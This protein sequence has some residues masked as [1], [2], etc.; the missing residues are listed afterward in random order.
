[1]HDDAKF[2][3]DLADFAA[4]VSASARSLG[5][6]PVLGADEPILYVDLCTG[7]FDRRKIHKAIHV[8]IDP[9]QKCKFLG[10]NISGPTV[11]ITLER[12]WQFLAF[13]AFLARLLQKPVM[14]AN[15]L[16]RGNWVNGWEDALKR[17]DHAMKS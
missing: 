15:P 6:Y 12:Q 8:N 10:V 1:M 13:V 5:S 2:L 11:E 14:I 16:I 9:S 4:Q 17:I 3:A 7:E